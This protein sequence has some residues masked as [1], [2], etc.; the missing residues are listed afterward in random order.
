MRGALELFETGGARVMEFDLTGR[1][2]AATGMICGGEVTVLLERIEPG[3]E[4][5]GIFEE[6]A[7]ALE[8]GGRA[9]L[10]VVLNGSGKQLDVES[11][12][13]LDRQGNVSAGEGNP[14][15]EILAFARSCES[16]SL[17]ESGGL[18]YAIEPLVP[19]NSAI[20]VGAGHVG[21]FTAE[22][23][24]KAGFRTVVVDDRADFANR[25]RFPDADE[26]RVAD[27]FTHCFDGLEIGESSFIVILTRGHVHDKDVLAA[28]LSAGAGYVGMIGSRRKRDAIYEAL[29]R[30]GAPRESLE[31]V[32][33]PVGLSIGAETPQ[34]IA[35]SIV[36]E[37]IKVRA[38]M[39]K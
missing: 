7:S 36:A 14:P 13:L 25:R 39:R 30:E 32:H 10:L 22:L 2:A 24:A 5:S 12:L 34:E 15:E 33:S 11:R 3:L 1:E 35:V 29:V 21:L 4:S 6:A 18:L 23:A 16:A 37:M 28:A 8:N 38:D 19:P 20:I 31:R 9:V 26:I 17:M 27:D